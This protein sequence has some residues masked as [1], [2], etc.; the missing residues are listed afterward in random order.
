M[1]CVN[2]NNFNHLTKLKI[3]HVQKQI[4]IK[5]DKAPRL[6]LVNSDQKQEMKKT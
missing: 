2:N 3:Q 6:V 4:K 1:K 5:K